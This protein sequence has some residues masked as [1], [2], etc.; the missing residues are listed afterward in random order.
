MRDSNDRDMQPMYPKLKHG[1]TSLWPEEKNHTKAASQSMTKEQ[2]EKGCR[3]PATPVLPGLLCATVTLYGMGR[4][5]KYLK[6]SLFDIFPWHSCLERPR[7][8]HL[9]HDDPK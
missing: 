8:A 3:V 7:R 2:C 9:T 5:G 6:E 1:I 4:I